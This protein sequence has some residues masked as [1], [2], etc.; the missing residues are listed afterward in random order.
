MVGSAVPRSFRRRRASRFRRCNRR[1]PEHNRRPAP[2]LFQGRGHGNR[3][4][5]HSF[6]KTRARVIG[7]KGDFETGRLIADAVAADFQAMHV[8]HCLA[9]KG[10]YR[11]SGVEF[12]VKLTLMQEASF[13]A[14]GTLVKVDGGGHVGD[15]NNCITEFHCV[16]P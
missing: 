2:G 4:G 13:Q 5:L 1:G 15:V 9:S 12:S 6:V 3:A 7:D 11:F 14:E 10:Q 16:I 8:S